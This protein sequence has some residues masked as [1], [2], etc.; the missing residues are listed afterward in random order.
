MPNLD[1]SYYTTSSAIAPRLW[2]QLDTTQSFYFSKSFLEACEKAN[3]AI[4][5]S[6][7]I[8]ETNNSAKG[9]AVIQSLS[10]KLETATAN[11]PLPQR[12][13]KTLQCYVS[14]RQREI[15]LCGNV[16]LSGNFGVYIVDPSLAPQMYRTLGRILP[17]VNTPKKAKV[18]FFKD[19][20]VQNQ[21]DAKVLERQ[22]YHPFEVAPNMIL[23]IKWSDFNSYKQSLKS[24]YRIKINKADTKSSALE[25][26]ELDAPE[27]F[28]YA[29]KLQEL[30]SNITE[31]ASFNA[32]E[33]D[34]RT[35]GFLKER[36]RESVI[37]N[38]YWLKDEMV[39]FAT[40]FV[41]EDQLDAHFIGL[42][43]GLNKTHS[44]YPR[45]L[46]DYVRLAIDKQVKV[47]NLGRTASEIKSTIGACPQPLLCYVKHKRTL[48]NSLFKPLV[49]QI[50]M[51]PY[52]QHQP[53]KNDKR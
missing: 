50:K 32:V 22:H 20:N 5:F 31:R 15:T 34:M 46:N 16:F 43:Y 10:V 21:A 48:A 3:P 33:M 26:R 35:Y 52:K 47:L 28:K 18:F 49:A 39:G 24:K 23:T 40:S 7:V 38:T 17:N 14:R 36:F 25:L 51:T 1:V 37:V 6:Y 12:F 9:L 8:F 29:P 53:F 45:I 13:L 11:L 19:F 30:Y 27:I 41:L 44:I 42:D 2:E 4:V